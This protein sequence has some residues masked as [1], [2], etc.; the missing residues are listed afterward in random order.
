MISFYQVIAAVPI[1]Y[2]VS[3]GYE[4]LNQMTYAAISS[5]NFFQF[6]SFS[7][8]FLGYTYGNKILILGLTV[9]AVTLLLYIPYMFLKARII[10]V[11]KPEKV[12]R[13]TWAQFLF[14]TTF[15]LFLVYPSVSFPVFYLVLC[16][17]VWVFVCVEMLVV[18]IL[19]ICVHVHVMCVFK[20]T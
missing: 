20:Y 18:Y 15:W 19:D 3:W 8:A 13:S 10:R 2:D 5:I 12:S 9:P 11:E 4:V 7:C 16:V 6:E 14:S 1:Q 17:S